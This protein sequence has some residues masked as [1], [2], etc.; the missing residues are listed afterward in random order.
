MLWLT[1]QAF[2]KV[3]RHRLILCPGDR[4]ATTALRDTHHLHVILKSTF[5]I[6]SVCIHTFCRDTCLIV[7][8][9]RVFVLTPNEEALPH[10]LPIFSRMKSTFRLLAHIHSRHF[11][12]AKQDFFLLLHLFEKKKRHR[13]LFLLISTEVLRH[14]SVSF[15]PTLYGSN[16]K[17]S[18]KHR[19]TPPTMHTQWWHK[20]KRDGHVWLM[21]NTKAF[22]WFVWF[23]FWGMTWFCDAQTW[24]TKQK[25]Q[26]E[27]PFVLKYSFI[28]EFTRISSTSKS[29]SIR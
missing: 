8:K 5:I 18:I 26:K 16:V 12:S 27:L 10:S 11:T 1:S 9:G 15:S 3:Q 17:C 7:S 19:V 25:K 24:K 28:C 20:A 2:K 21:L 29:N 6:T 22:F 13:F 23:F 14:R 4:L